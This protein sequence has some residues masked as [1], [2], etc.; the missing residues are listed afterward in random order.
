MSAPAPIWL[1][2]ADV[3]AVVGLAE[4]I[5]AVEEGFRAEAAGTA[6]NLVKTQLGWKDGSLHAVGAVFEP[7]GLAG[8]KTWL[9][10]HGGADPLLLLFG[11]GD[12][13]L[14]AV[15]EAFALGQLRT[16]AVSA[17]ATH[18][19]AEPTASVLAICGTGAQAL[20]QVAAVAAVRPL[21]MVRV[22]GRDPQR[23]RALVDRIR[24]ELDLPA[25]G[26]EDPAAAVSA[27]DVITLATRAT[28]PF[29]AADMP[30]S[31]AH[32][33]AMGAITLERAEFEPRLLD[34]CRVVAV[35]SLA[36]ARAH[37]RELRERLG[38][39]DAAWARVLPLSRLVADAARRPAGA[40]LTL[41]KALGVG[42]ADVALGAHVYREALARGIGRPLEP[43][44]RLPPGLRVSA[45]DATK[46]GGSRS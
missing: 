30:E 15:I 42:L 32:V 45:V 22:Y 46:E 36:Q 24:S 38:D 1:T 26:Y 18:H 21:R 34:R 16:A 37:S 40:D 44:R 9:H 5:E 27:A 6:R 12:G 3:V 39:E 29:L 31:G 41:C 43:T 4:A 19:L 23:R 2:E 33:N 35:D 17:V 14:R 25:E 28:T 8:T 11:T 13:R 20:P 10:A 7:A